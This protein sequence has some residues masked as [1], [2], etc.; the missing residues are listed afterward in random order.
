VPN[1]RA[2][3][4]ATAAAV[5][6]LGAAWALAQQPA[7]TPAATPS[8]APAASPKPAP[9]PDV[10]YLRN[11]D[12]VTGRT[13]T[14]GKRSFAIQ[15]PFGR[16]NVPRARVAKVVHAD[17]TE[18]VLQP[19][20]AAEAAPP[21]VP[22]PAP[23]PPPSARLVLAITGKTFW[24][25]W[26]AREAGRDL[27]LRLELRLDEEPVVVYSD[28]EPDPDE[29]PGALVNA[30]AFAEGLTVAPVPGVRVHPAEVRPGRI[31]LKLDLPAPGPVARRL[32]MAY[33][34]NAGTAEEP[35][36]RDVV[37]AATEV[38]L[39]DGQPALVEA[40]QDRGRME[41]AGFPRRRMRHVDTFALSLEATTPAAPAP[42]P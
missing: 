20:D 30:F 2:R 16:L 9:P 3:H 31:V 29:I 21:A 25:A 15:T 24:Q 34:V 41:F 7:P 23:A 12:R 11:G 28:N 26:D 13:L 35:A 36:W 5:L 32:R 39:A 14:R 22:V 1:V 10:Y 40:A 42:A 37:S 4:V 19:V 18:E 33:Q 17:G 6:G 8:P 27:T 38:T